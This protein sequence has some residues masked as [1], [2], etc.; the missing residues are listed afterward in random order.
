[1]SSIRFFKVEFSLFIS[2][3]SASNSMLRALKSV[4]LD[5]Y[6]AMSSVG[7]SLSSILLGVACKN[8]EEVAFALFRDDSSSLACVLAWWLCVHCSLVEVAIG[9][10]S[11]LA[12]SALLITMLSVFSCGLVGPVA[13]TLVEK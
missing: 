13:R 11:V 12:P 10:I 8:G 6:S 2:L 7:E 1:M 9:V 3:F 5:L 4:S